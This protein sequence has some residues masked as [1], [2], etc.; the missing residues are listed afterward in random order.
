MAL[1]AQ[2]S[3]HHGQCRLPDNPVRSRFSCTFSSRASEMSRAVTCAPIAAS[4]NVLPPGAAHM[5]RTRLPATSP[6]VL[7][8]VLPQHPEPT[9][10][11]VNIRE[12]RYGRIRVPRSEH[13][14]LA[15]RFHLLLQVRR[16]GLHAAR[17]K[18]RSGCTRCACALV[19]AALLAKVRAKFLAE[20]VW[21]VCQSGRQVLEQRLPVFSTRR[22]TAFTRDL[23]RAD[24]LSFVASARWC[25]W[26]HALRYRETNLCRA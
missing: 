15:I 14:R 22:R 2:R 12:R 24:D 3:V 13:C 26:L 8:V 10:G 20:P 1:Q 23:N 4:C 5:S 21:Q 16:Y 11:L 17:V 18:S 6:T 19:M 9:S 7:P 25:R